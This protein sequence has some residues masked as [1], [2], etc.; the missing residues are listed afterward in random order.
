MTAPNVIPAGATVAGAV[1]EPQTFA[2]AQPQVFNPGTVTVAQPTVQAPAG[3]TPFESLPADVQEYIKSLRGENKEKRL[4]LEE[5]SASVQKQIQ[6]AQDAALK[7]QQQQL[8]K[9]L[10]LTDKEAE[11]TPEQL[12]QQIQ[13]RDAQITQQAAQIKDLQRENA[14]ISA[15]NASEGIPALRDAVLGSRKLAALDPGANDFD[16]KVL[17]VVNEYLT[18][19]P[20]FKRV[21][22]P[23]ILSTEASSGFEPGSGSSSSTD[24][25]GKTDLDKVR[26]ERR[27]RLAGKS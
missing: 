24:G 26:E 4:T 2:A 6:D 9:A 20:Q 22:T 1:A 15:V 18:A 16:E 19:N 3:Q 17:A 5:V 12:T 25:S 10:G 27:K 23:Q 13:E 14:L 8:A 21:V 7:A 11:V